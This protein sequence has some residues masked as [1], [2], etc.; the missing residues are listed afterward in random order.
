M[1]VLTFRADNRL[2]DKVTVVTK[3]FMRY[4]CLKRFLESAQL[5]YPGIRVIVADD[6]PTKYR[7]TL[8]N[9]DF[10]HVSQYFMPEFTGWFAGRALAISQVETDF[11]V[12]VDDDFVFNTET[13]LQYMLDVIETT[14]LQKLTQI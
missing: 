8:E 4:D 13:D 7:E 12:W 9:A 1:P 14:G 2:V 10:P 3:T 6:S 5:F 11:F